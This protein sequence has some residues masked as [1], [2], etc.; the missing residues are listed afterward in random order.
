MGFF[1]W[2]WGQEDRSGAKKR[3][4]ISFAIE[5]VQY[6][7]YLVE[8]SR[9]ARSP[10]DF[11]DM[12]VKQPWKEAE[13]QRRCRVKI[14][15]CHGMIVLLSTH[16][17]H[18][19]GARWEVRCAQQERIPVVGMHINKRSKGAVPPELHRSMVTEWSWRN[20]ENFINQL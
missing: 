4:F 8:Q 7:D 6:R 14:R 3:I 16:T 2:L 1:N 10:F 5:D 18:S 9:Q 13:W 19:K 15:R 20:L 12:S 11:I 17:Y